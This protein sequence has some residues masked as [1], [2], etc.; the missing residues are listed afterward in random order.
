MPE[1]STSDCEA[2][3]AASLAS[4]EEQIAEKSAE[5]NQLLAERGDPER[6]IAASDAK[7]SQPR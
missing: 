5:A 3:P 4:A 7:K 6:P 1:D 2:E